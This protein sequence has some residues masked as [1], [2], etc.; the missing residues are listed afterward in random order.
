MSPSRMR[1]QNQR[2][3]STPRHQCSSPVWRKITNPG[4]QRSS[5]PVSMSSSPSGRIS[6]LPK[7]DTPPSML[8][9]GSSKYQQR[10]PS[11]SPRDGYGVT[12]R[13]APDHQ[14]PRK[15]TAEH[16]TEI[17]KASNFSGNLPPSP[18]LPKGWRVPALSPSPYNSP[19]DYVSPPAARR[20]PRKER[21]P[22]PRKRQRETMNSKDQVDRV[23]LEEKDFSRPRKDRRGNK[24]SVNGKYDNS[25]Y[26]PEKLTSHLPTGT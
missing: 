8:R 4:Q 18:P 6:I 15:E 2:A 3:P 17:R 19:L 25:K 23:E 10:S 21:S 22:I 13:N 20:T 14:M 11:E 1:R 7:R 5:C 24:N 12:Q 16:P 26:S 9:R